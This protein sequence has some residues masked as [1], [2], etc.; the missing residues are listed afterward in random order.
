MTLD[1]L[2]LNNFKDNGDDA[3]IDDSELEEFI[4]GWQWE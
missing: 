2:D 3:N 1:K 4:T